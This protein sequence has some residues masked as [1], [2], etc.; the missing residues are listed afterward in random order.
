MAE[1]RRER[2]EPRGFSPYFAGGRVASHFSTAARSSPLRRLRTPSR[3]DAMVSP[4]SKGSD[5]Y[6]L[7]PGSWQGAQRAA[8]TGRTV[9][10]KASEAGAA[11]AGGFGSSEVGGEPGRK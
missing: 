5:P 8:R 10:A 7:P 3:W 4:S 9:A 11:S 2:S 1:I 6:I